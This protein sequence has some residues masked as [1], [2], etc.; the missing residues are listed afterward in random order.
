MV[1]AVRWLSMDDLRRLLSVGDERVRR[2]VKIY[3]FSGARHPPGDGTKIR[4][5][6][7]HGLRHSVLDAPAK[8]RRNRKPRPSAGS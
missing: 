1:S 5:F 8:R 4:A 7:P 2:M 3:L 6:G